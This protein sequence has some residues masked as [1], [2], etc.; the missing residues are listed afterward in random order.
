MRTKSCSFWWAVGAGLLFGACS[1]QSDAASGE[2]G[3][4]ATGGCADNNYAVCMDFEKLPDTK[5]TGFSATDLQ[6][7]QAAHGLAAFHGPPTNKIT[8]TQL[9]TITNVMW[10]RFYLH[11]TPKAPVGHGELIG[12]FDQAGNWYEVGFEFNALQGNWHGN[13]GEKYMRTKMVLPD[14][15]VCVEFL[16]DGAMGA[17]VQLWMDGTQ[18]Q[19]YDI[20]STKGPNVATKFTKFEIG[21]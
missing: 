5:W 21:F 18:I 20:G 2:G 11:M 8:T 16:M 1:A 12:V 17:A 6:M 9:G 3:P 13:G 19:Y 15:Y 4:V 14:K 10:G 7:G